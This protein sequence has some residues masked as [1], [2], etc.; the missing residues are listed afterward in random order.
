MQISFLVPL[1]L[2]FASC[3]QADK[4]NTQK[5]KQAAEIFPVTS[6]IKGQI[7]IVDSF[8]LPTLKYITA[9]NKKDSSL[10]SINEFKQLAQE[11]LHPDINNLQV[12]SAYK[13]SSFADQSIKGV[14]FTYATDNKELEIQRLD[15]IVSASPVMNDKVRSIYMEKQSVSGDT[16]IYKKLYWKTDKNFQIITTTQAGEQPAVTSV[17]KVEWD[18][19]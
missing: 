15:V 7:H 10:I 6:F 16:A 12:S 1:V 3:H 17:M 4:S 13:E 5:E 8:Q 9:N 14:T 19:D 18:K 2:F 11:F